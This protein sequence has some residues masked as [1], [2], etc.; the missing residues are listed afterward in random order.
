MSLRGQTATK[1]SS[2]LLSPRYEPDG[3]RQVG[4]GTANSALHHTLNT[5]SFRYVEVVPEPSS[6]LLLSVGLLGLAARRRRAAGGFGG[7]GRQSAAFGVVAQPLLAPPVVTSRMRTSACEAAASGMISSARM[8]AF[9][10]GVTSAAP[11][12]AG[13]RRSRTGPPVPSWCQAKAQDKLGWL[14]P[15]GSGL[16]GLTGRNHVRGPHLPW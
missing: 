12:G 2:P 7:D 5:A 15:V 6:A 13:F 14:L 4:Y 9:S 1:P 11:P 16:T 10:T 8:L 3:G